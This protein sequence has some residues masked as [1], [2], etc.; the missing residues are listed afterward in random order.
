MGF[1]AANAE[2]AK[3]DSEL[4]TNNHLQ[5]GNWV[6]DT[7]FVGIINGVRRLGGRIVEI[8]SMSGLGRKCF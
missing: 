6:N 8:I 1:R 2:R 4:L 5:I 3:N 7:K